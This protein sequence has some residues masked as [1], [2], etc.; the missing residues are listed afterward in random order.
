MSRIE[1]VE[2]EYMR[3]LLDVDEAD[4]AIEDLGV[5]YQLVT[6]QTS[7]VVLSNEA[8][9]KHGIDRRNQAR[10]TTEREA[11]AKRRNAP[12]RDQRVDRE[13]PMFNWP[14]PSP[15]GGAVD[16]VS[17]LLML[18]V[19]GWAVIVRLRESKNRKGLPR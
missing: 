8:F 3:G 18:G 17:A 10:V 15:G 7:M 16:P 19:G 14:A 12:P 6:D 11:Q 9:A 4:S 1:A 13:R 5:A 2:A